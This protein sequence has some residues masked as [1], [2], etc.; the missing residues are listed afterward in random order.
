[1][2]DLNFGRRKGEDEAGEISTDM[3]KVNSPEEALPNSGKFI[4]H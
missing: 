4:L 2:H 1:M 3:T